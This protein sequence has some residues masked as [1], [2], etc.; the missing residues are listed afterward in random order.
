MSARTADSGPNPA[1]LFLSLAAGLAG[2][3]MFARGWFA[4]GSALVAASVGVLRWPGGLWSVATPPELS[5][6]TRLLCLAAVV[7]V[8]AFFRFHRLV[9]PGLWGDDA[10]NGM[11]AFDVLDGKITSP[12]RIIQHSISRMHALTNYFIAASFQLFGPDLWSLRFPGVALNFLCV[13]IVYFL[14]APLFG[15]RVALGGALFFASAPVQVSHGKI[16]IQVATGEFFLLLSLCLLVRGVHGARRWLIPLAAVPLALSLCT[17]LS[18]KA[19]PLVIP[20]AI[21]AAWPPKP[22]RRRLGWWLAAAVGV[23]AAAAAPGIL[24]YVDEPV[25]LFGRVGNTSSWAGGLPSMWDS[26]W[27]TLAIF[28]YQQGP[29]QVNWVGVGFD[30]ALGGPVALLAC[31]GLIESLRR[32]RQRRHLFLLAWFV[33]GLLPGILSS[34]APRVYRVLLATPPLFLWAALPLER[35]AAA[36]LR[37]RTDQRRLAA[38]ATGAVAAAIVLGQP[39]L[40]FDYYFHRV[41]THHDYNASQATRMVAMADLLRSHGPGWSGQVFAEGFNTNHDTMRFLARAWNLDIHDANSLT[42]ILPPKTSGNT[43][44]LFDGS[45]LP[46][47]EALRVL[48]PAA[49]TETRNLSPQQPPWVDRNL[50]GVSPGTARPLA[51]SLALT[52]A[53]LDRQRG[54]QARYLDE[55]GAP[56][57]QRIWPQLATQGD[58][59]PPEAASVSLSGS[60]FAPRDGTYSFALD[61]GGAATTLP[62]SILLDGRPLLAGGRRRAELDLAEGFHSLSA[63]VELEAGGTFDV[64]WRPPGE[65]EGSIPGANLWQRRDVPGWL[66]E[67]TTAARTIRRLE[68]IPF[69]N[70]FPRTFEGPFDA[71][72]RGRIVVPA[73]G[74]YIEIHSRVPLQVQVDGQ[75]ANPNERLEGGEHAVEVKMDQVTGPQSLLVFWRTPGQ[76]SEI[77]PPAALLPPT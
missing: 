34:E 6:R 66:A 43:L 32:I 14:F 4:A 24:S 15:A 10:I 46:A 62:A 67:Y 20:F 26:L 8:G 75:P 61:E 58:D 73:D 9:P 52:N 55:K 16:L 23:F 17:Y 71:R 53:A 29:R 13:P 39:L 54:I 11:L 21:A 65:A 5:R 30:P 68:P 25:A 69:Y 76:A 50:L 41:Y 48:Y 31:H 63:M 3:E 60:L 12:F 19:L 22:R 1:F 45:T 51:G 74:R 77:V 72:W 18:L 40:D 37:A 33:I 35:I 28:H 7:A 56:L 2:T 42:E 27:R 38:A 70:F 64:R 44:L 57:F 59:E 36:A 49:P 47:R